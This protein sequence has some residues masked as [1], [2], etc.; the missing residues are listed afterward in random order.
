MAQEMQEAEAAKAAAAAV[1]AAAE[2]DRRAKARDVVAT[3]GSGAG[4]L[5]ARRATT[6]RRPLGL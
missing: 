4:P 2:T 3:P 5:A 1:S 6:P